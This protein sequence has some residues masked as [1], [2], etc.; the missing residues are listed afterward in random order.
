MVRPTPPLP[1]TVFMVLVLRLLR[2]VL[3]MSANA[4]LPLPLH[5]GSMVRSNVATSRTISRC[6]GQ[7][8]VA[9]AIAVVV[10]VGISGGRL[11]AMSMAVRLI[12]G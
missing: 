7:W 12:W 1:D 8:A 5:T 10:I 4:P 6:T 2:L 9:T 3:T 11:P